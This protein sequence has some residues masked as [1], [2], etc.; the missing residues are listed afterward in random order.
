MLSLD[1][2]ERLPLDTYVSQHIMGEVREDEMEDCSDDE[3]F[4][5]CQVNSK[6][7]IVEV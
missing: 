7:I 4:R 5:C 3:G 1:D 6:G 2:L